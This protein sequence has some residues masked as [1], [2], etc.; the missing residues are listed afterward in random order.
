MRGSCPKTTI[1]VSQE[2]IVWVSGRNPWL[3]AAMFRDWTLAMHCRPTKKK[4]HISYLSY[5]RQRGE[6]CLVQAFS[7]HVRL[8]LSSIGEGNESLRV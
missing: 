5:H 7:A 6:P 3:T 1:E 8:D 4:T 2:L